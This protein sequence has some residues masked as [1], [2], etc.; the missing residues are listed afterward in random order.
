MKKKLF[1]LLTFILCACAEKT[2]KSKVCAQEMIDICNRYDDAKELN[3]C[4]NRHK[5][6]IKEDCHKLTSSGTTTSK[7][8]ELPANPE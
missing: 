1:I 8:M 3:D 6:E 7:E 5:A 4:I 2:E